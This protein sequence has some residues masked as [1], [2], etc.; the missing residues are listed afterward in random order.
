MSA[1]VPTAETRPF[2]DGLKARELRVRWCS[3]CGRLE[4]PRALLC[5]RCLNPLDWRP[6]SGRGR[7]TSWTVVRRSFVPGF[8]PPYVVGAVGLDEQPDLVLDTTF[9]IGADA[10]STGL[11]VEVVFHDDRRGFSRY[12][13]TAVDSGRNPLLT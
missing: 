8:A 10:L 6:V 1:P 3:A 4:H 9:D 5:P 11:P 13:F 2:W 7:V 12:A